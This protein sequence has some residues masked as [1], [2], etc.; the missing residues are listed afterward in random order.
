MNFSYWI[1]P[2][3]GIMMLGSPGAFASESLAPCPNSPNCVSTQ[4]EDGKH[5][6]APLPYPGTGQEALEKL[7]GIVFAMPRTEIVRRTETYL[8]ATYTSQLFRFKDDVEFLV[9]EEAKMVHF[10]SASRSGWSDLGANRKRMEAI[11]AK[12]KE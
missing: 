2:I 12:F 10:R 1:I 6:M 3:A 8:H 7:A 9:D 11:I 4:A 5:A